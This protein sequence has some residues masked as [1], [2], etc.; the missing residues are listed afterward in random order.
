MR[1]LVRRELAPLTDEISVD[2][3]GN[4]IASKGKGGPKV[5]LAAHMD[6]I[7]FMVEWGK[8]MTRDSCD[9]SRWVAGIHAPCLHSASMCMV[10][11]EKHCWVH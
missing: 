7:G 3:M 9:C 10:S 1:S 8:R 2:A 6:E 11:L 4:L 5:M